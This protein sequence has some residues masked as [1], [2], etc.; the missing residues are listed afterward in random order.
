EYDRALRL[1]D[2]ARESFVAGAEW[3]KVAQVQ[4]VRGVV[5]FASGNLRE[6]EELLL[7]ACDGLA[8]H[9]KARHLAVAACHLGLVHLETH[10]LPEARAAFER[11]HA[12]LRAFPGDRLTAV[13]EANLAGLFLRQGRHR[14]AERM[15]TAAEATLAAAGQPIR[16]A[17]CR[18]NRGGTRV[19]LGDLDAALA[20]LAAARAV[21]APHPAHRRD[22]AAC[23]VNIGLA[24]SA[25][26]EHDRALTHIGRAR[27]VYAELE[28]P[29]EAARCDFLAATVLADREPG[30]LRPALDLALPA[31][32]FIDDQRLRFVHA[33]T[34]S[35]WAA[36][37]ALFRATVFEWCA[38]LGD[39]VLLAELVEVSLNSGTHTP[40]SAESPARADHLAALAADIAAG[41][42]ADP[43]LL[44]GAG[45]RAPAEA[46]A[47]ATA[48]ALIAG[49]A[50]PMRPPPRLRMPDGSI[51]LAG[52]LDSARARYGDLDRPW[53]VRTW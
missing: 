27:A 7:D 33:R 51:A 50:L 10:R 37:S 17:V 13:V 31:L 21:F 40:A 29:L 4:D 41:A 45:M 47:H 46:P 2:E 52:F 53:E 3:A 38:R 11:S 1:L 9:G 39:P 32:L 23:E 48:G 44:A 18:Q 25:R 5:Q 34:R 8:R 43:G 16:A 49:A 22:G 6:A 19:L 42:H 36:R 15:Y 20:D 12:T 26:G 28:L 35:A 30:D 24:H 14:D